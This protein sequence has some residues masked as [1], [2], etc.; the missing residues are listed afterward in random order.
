LIDSSF[1]QN[2][3]S[4]NGNEINDIGR[5]DRGMKS[6]NDINF[7]LNNFKNINRAFFI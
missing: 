2:K 3:A 1:G 5:R 4:T 7:A 6:I